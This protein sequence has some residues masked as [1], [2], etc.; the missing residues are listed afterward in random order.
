MRDLPDTP[1]RTC[2]SRKARLPLSGGATA[3]RIALAWGVLSLASTASIAQNT[4]ILPELRG[5][6]SDQALQ[7]PQASP[8]SGGSLFG[9]PP[10]SFAQGLQPTQ[11][12][13]GTAPEPGDQAPLLGTTPLPTLEQGVPQPPTK[14]PPATVVQPQIRR[15]F[16]LS[17]QTAVHGVAERPVY[18]A[19]SPD[20]V[21]RQ[22]QLPPKLDGP[23][24][25]PDHPPTVEPAE[26]PPYT[27]AEQKLLDARRRALRD[28]DPYAPLGLRL[29]SLYLFPSIEESVGYDTNPGQVQG[30][31]GSRESRTDGEIK[32]QSDWSSDELTGDLRGGYSYFPDVKGAN[33]PD[34]DG[35]VDL[36]IDATK[37]LNLTFEGRGNLSTQQPGSVNLPVATQSRPLVWTYGG[38]VGTTY[39][40]GYWN[41]TL[42]GNID[43]FVYENAKLADGT[44]LIQSDRD[45]TQYELRARLG[46]DVTPGI[47]PFVEGRVD[48][49]QYDQTFDSSG[50]AR[51]SD[52]VAALAGTAFEFTRTLTGEV[53]AGYADR[54]YR[55][56]RLKD[57]KGPLTEASLVWSATPLTTVTLKGSTQLVE[58]TLPF[59]PG[60][61]ERQV[62]LEVSHA[63]LRNLIIT[64][65]LGWIR[66]RYEENIERDTTI[67]AGVKAEWRLTRNLVVKAS[68]LRSRE[69]SNVPG[70]EYGENTYLMGM[71]LQF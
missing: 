23:A 10:P 7:Q 4:T 35:K 13:A 37:D 2:Q 48:T 41:F 29:G 66:D 19:T 53:S 3:G 6:S 22:D 25:T 60:A 30:G 27:P 67:T 9:V 21:T 69:T 1:S 51:T 62:G 33:R 17:P 31:K 43:R 36:R 28:A 54:S 47:K 20:R 46:Y 15:R 14:P 5:V 50:F 55:D 45:M 8:E 58:T 59:S 38:S 70:R 40:P 34:G 12:G 24:G 63:L 32:L 71:R 65:S 68:F 26:A 52:G 61:L 56:A 18:V 64:G 57:L 16:G 42:R 44:T 11:P 49:R 39:H